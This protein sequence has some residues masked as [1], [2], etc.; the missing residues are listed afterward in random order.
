V[1]NLAQVERDKAEMLAGL[2]EGLA[3]QP[4]A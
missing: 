1:R 2:V 4:G 3:P